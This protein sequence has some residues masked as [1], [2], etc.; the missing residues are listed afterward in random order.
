MNIKP[1]KI[2]N[3]IFVF[4]TMIKNIAVLKKKYPAYASRMA[5][6]DQ[7]G[8]EI[9]QV[10]LIRLLTNMVFKYKLTN[11]IHREEAFNSAKLLAILS[12]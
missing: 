3:V 2:Q 9:I 11:P 6:Y 5:D 7:I 4:T 12:T 8:Q 10:F 1:N